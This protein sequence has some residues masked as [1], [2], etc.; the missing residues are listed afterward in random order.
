MTPG[1]ARAPTCGCRSKRPSIICSPGPRGP[2]TS[3]PV[4]SR[5]RRYFMVS[6][7]PESLLLEGARRVDEWSQIEKKIPSF[8]LIFA[9]DPGHAPGE[10]VGLSAAQRTAPAPA[11]R[12]S[13]RASGHRR[14]LAGR[15]RGGR[16]A[17]R[18]D[19]RG[20]RAP[21]RHFRQ[22]PLRRA[23]TRPGSRSTRTSASRSTR[24]AC[25]TK[26]SGSSAG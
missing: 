1:T 23:P 2:S 8:D 6:I 26:P 16:R 15:V 7:N 13:R 3:R 19:H 22:G 4:S 24:P 25:W 5:N 17:V 11:R 21:G 10:D 14:V 20:V 12:H 18:P 9:V